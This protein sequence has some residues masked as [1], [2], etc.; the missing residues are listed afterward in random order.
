MKVISV[1][2]G[3]TPRPGE[4]AY[5]QAEELGAQ[6]AARGFSVANGGYCGTMEA[7]S[8][9]AAEAGG[10]VIGV[11]CTRLETY[12]PVGP[13][14]WISRE[15]RVETVADRLRKLVTIG[16]GFIALPGGIGTLAEIAQSWSW[17]QTG[18]IERVPLIL[19]GETWRA[20][21]DMFRANAQGYLA[22]RDLALLSF[23]PDAAGAVRRLDEICADSR[24]CCAA[25]SR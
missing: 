21:L 15:I 18:E 11:T 3:S 19:V 10:T 1:F 4:P 22:E 9:G 24:G 16:D 5:Q 2:G 17:M 13:N 14:A 12:R 8:R 25:S 20:V 7:V 6:L 23:E